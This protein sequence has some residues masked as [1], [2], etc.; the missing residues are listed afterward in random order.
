MRLSTFDLTDFLDYG[1]KNALTVRV[2]A[3]LGEGWFDKG[4]GIYRHVWLTKTAPIHVAQWGTFVQ[5]LVQEAG[6]EI[7]IQTEVENDGD[8]GKACAVI[9]RLLDAENTIVGTARSKPQTISPGGS[10]AFE[11][12]VS[13]KNPRLWSLE[14]RHLYRLITEVEV[15]GTKVDQTETPFG[16]RTI[17][18]DADNG[19]FLNRKPMKIKGTCNHQDHAGFGAAGPVA[20]L[21]H[22]AAERNGF[23]R[24]SH[25]APSPYSGAPGRM[26]PAGD[27]GYGRNAHDVLHSGRVQPT[28]AGDSARSQSSEHRDLVARQR[29]MVCAKHAPGRSNCHGHETAGAE[30]G[31]YAP[32]DVGDEWGLGQ[33]RVRRGGCARVQ[34]RWRAQCGARHGQKHR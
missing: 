7:T 34:L 23:K 29:G 17:R 20:A 2:D 26:R 30:A 10:F 19:F 32:C 13:A 15:D 28:G 21:P 8:E 16:I 6:A 33:R 5:S 31:S 22:R 24:L 18:L 9:S 1:G 27:A 11:S 25:V 4:A 3:T 14:E 12:H